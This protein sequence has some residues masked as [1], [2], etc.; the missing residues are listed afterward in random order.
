[1]FDSSADNKERIITIENTSRDEIWSL[2][3]ARTKDYYA[4]GEIFGNFCNV[5]QYINVPVDLAY[6]YLSNIE[7]LEEWTFSVRSLKPV[8]GGLYEGIEAI[9]ENTK[10]YIRADC[11]PESRVIDWP[12]AWDQNEDLW[13]FYATRL[14]DAKHALGTDG[15]VLIW[16]NFR[17]QNYINGPRPELIEGWNYMQVIHGLEANNLRII[18]ENKYRKEEEHC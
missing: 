2:I 18:L 3:K 6:D 4:H 13:M 8:G 5:N 11:Y 14:V 9:V 16:T 12:C 15:T 17:H 1:M 7:N 10:I